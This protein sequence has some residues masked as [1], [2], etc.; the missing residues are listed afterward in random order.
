MDR[1]L[2]AYYF[3]LNTKRM[4]IQNMLILGDRPEDIMLRIGV[5]SGLITDVS[6]KILTNQPVTLDV[7][8]SLPS[9]VTEQIRLYIESRTFQEPSL[10]SIRLSAEISER[11]KT[12]ICRKTVDRT[13]HDLKFKYQAPIKTFLL[14]DDQKK[15]RAEFVNFHIDNKTDW[16]KVLFTDESYF[17]VGHNKKLLWKRKGDHRPEVL[18]LKIAHPLKIMV[19]GGISKRFKTGLFIFNNKETMTAERYLNRIWKTTNLISSLNRQYPDGWILQQDNASSHKAKIVMDFFKDSVHILENWPPH[20]P[21]LNVIE[22]IWA[23]MKMKLVEMMPSDE[24]SLILCLREIWFSIT[25]E[26]IGNLVDS[27][28]RR[29]AK[30]KETNGKQIIGHV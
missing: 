24:A 27:I 2:T 14:T 3:D 29:L 7:K 30:V 8:T 26:H 18:E 22:L 17:E 19:W 21:D 15:Y 11:F 10:S 20:S 6:K 4:Q 13:R 12:T 5:S 28:P 23:W 9:K 16:D 25:P 1:N